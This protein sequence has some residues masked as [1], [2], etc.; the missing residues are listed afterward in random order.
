MQGLVS[1]LFVRMGGRLLLARLGLRLLRGVGSEWDLRVILMGLY[2]F[3]GMF[4]ED[5]GSLRPR[6]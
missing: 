5:S 6:C 4:H 1:G 3:L 2:D